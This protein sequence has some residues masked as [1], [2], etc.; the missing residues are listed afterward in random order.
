MTQLLSC[1]CHPPFHPSPSFL[2]RC[3]NSNNGDSGGGGELCLQQQPKE[4]TITWRF[5]SR[6]LPLLNSYK[7]KIKTENENVKENTHYVPD[8]KEYSISSPY[9]DPSPGFSA[10]LWSKGFSK[11]FHT[12]ISYTSS[13]S[14]VYTCPGFLYLDILR[15]IA[16]FDKWHY[17]HYTR[18]EV[19]H[20]LTKSLTENFFVQRS[21]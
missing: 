10:T 8:T 12:V 9:S 21:F 11:T 4:V 18:N 3:R 7:K 19:F 13:L 17:I 16:P 20:L 5:W 14:T 2:A 1:H 15:G 6:T